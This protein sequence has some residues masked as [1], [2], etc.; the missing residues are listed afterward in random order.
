[1]AKRSSPPGVVLR[2]EGLRRDYGGVRCLHSVDL[3]I[4]EGRVLGLVGRNGAGKTTLLRILAGALQPTAGRVWRPPGLRVG[5]A[6]EGDGA[7]YSEL[8]VRSYLRLMAGLTEA[9]AGFGPDEVIEA[10]GL[11][12]RAHQEIR[13]LSRGFRQ[14]VLLGQALLG[15]PQVLLLDEPLNSLDPIQIAEMCRLLTA[16]PWSPAVVVSSHIVSHLL[17]IAEE[18]VLVANGEVVRAGTVAEFAVSGSGIGVTARALSPAT[19]VAA[20][21]GTLVPSPSKIVERGGVTWITVPVTGG[22]AADQV[23]VRVL[24][25]LVAAKIKVLEIA[26]RQLRIA[27]R[28]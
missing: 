10:M 21:L 11:A 17:D 15:A 1:M 27:E 25:A 6:P 14:R 2:A 12:E 23:A 7:L 4:R 26:P 20:A 8:T 3:V 28:V 5:F 16:L 24:E 9:G 18:I 22:M 13:A 19:P